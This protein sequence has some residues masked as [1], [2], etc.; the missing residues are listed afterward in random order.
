MRAIARSQRRRPPRSFTGPG[1]VTVGTVQ[2]DEGAFRSV[3]AENVDW[4]G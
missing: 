3:L 2:L 4:G 1:S